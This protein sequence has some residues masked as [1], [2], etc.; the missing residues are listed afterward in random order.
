MSDLP[1]KKKKKKEK[2]K[3]GKKVPALAH[4]NL[5][6]CLHNKKFYMH[7]PKKTKKQS[8]R[9]MTSDH[10][11]STRWNPLSWAS[12]VWTK[13]ERDVTVIIAETPTFE[14]DLC[15][16]VWDSPQPDHGKGEH[17]VVQ[18][19][20]K[21]LCVQKKKK[22]KEKRCSTSLRIVFYFVVNIVMT[23]MLCLR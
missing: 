3:K 18:Q 13:W 11:C 2:E 23:W 5:K 4:V 12:S 10:M 8:F 6:I 19:G 7:L 9:K 17:V 22:E 21:I 15:K 1:K 16:Q 14:W 20:F